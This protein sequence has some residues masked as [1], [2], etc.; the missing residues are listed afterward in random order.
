MWDPEL[1]VR[2]FRCI[3]FSLFKKICHEHVIHFIMR[4]K[5]IH[6]NLFDVSE[7]LFLKL[8]NGL[9]SSYQ[10]PHPGDYQAGSCPIF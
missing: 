3:Y 7:Q 9:G 2:I 1:Y 8:E 6:I 4:T 5:K 10:F